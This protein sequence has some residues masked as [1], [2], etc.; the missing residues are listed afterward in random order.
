MELYD[1]DN[2]DGPDHDFF[3]AV[4]NEAGAETVV[5]LGCGTG[6][7]TVTFC[8]EDRKVIGIDPSP[9]MLGYA[10]RRPGAGQVAWILGDSSAI[11]D[12]AA[13][14]VVMSGN[15]AQ[16]ITGAAWRRA[17]RDIHR[18]LRP[19]GVL[20]FERR[21][22]LARSWENWTKEKTLTTR[23]SIIGQLMEWKEVSSMDGAGIV[24]LTCHNVLMDTGED[25]VETLSLSFLSQAQVVS[26]LDAAGFDVTGVWRNWTRE[27]VEEK[28]PLM[29]FEATRRH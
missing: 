16:H 13:D 7:L 2:P 17:L 5:D 14:V 26:D 12:S 6:I 1:T 9:A 21:N 19:G 20:A 15:V 22:V 24:T 28:S 27:P 11:G 10:R 23:D 4:T 3:R 18:G 29:V 25:I 8:R